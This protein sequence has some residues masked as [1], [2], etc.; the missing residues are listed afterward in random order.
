MESKFKININITN[1]EDDIDNVDIKMESDIFEKY[2]YLRDQLINDKIYPDEIDLILMKVNHN[3]EL[4]SQ[5]TTLFKG[6]Y[7]DVSKC[8]IAV[9]KAVK[10]LLE[11]LKVQ[12]NEADERVAEQKQ[13]NEQ[14]QKQVAFLM[15]NTNLGND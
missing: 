5:L 14:L 7:F 13:I 11:K 2:I 12:Q 1:L 8:D 9:A 6:I 15:K 4:K 10:P 3:I